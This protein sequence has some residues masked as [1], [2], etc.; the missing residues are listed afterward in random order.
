LNILTR[1]TASTWEPSGTGIKFQGSGATSV[2]SSGG[3]ITISSTNTTYATR[4]N[5]A[6]IYFVNALETTPTTVS[7]DGNTAATIQYS[8]VGASP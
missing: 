5:P 4:P 2:T 7:Y 8:D 6:K 1:T 3:I